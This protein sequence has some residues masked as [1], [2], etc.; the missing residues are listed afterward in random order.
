MWPIVPAPTSPGSSPE[1]KWGSSSPAATDRE[2]GFERFGDEGT[3]VRQED[4]PE[5]QG[6]QAE[7]GGSGDLLEDPKAQAEAGL[8]PGLAVEARLRGPREIADFV[9]WK[10]QAEA[11]L[12]PGLAVEAR[13]RGPREI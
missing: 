13:L 12:M 11:G 9:G 3:A 6:D 5:L 7:R 10:S 2:G 4:V 8:M 1:T